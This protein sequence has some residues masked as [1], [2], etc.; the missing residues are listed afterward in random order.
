MEIHF[1]KF[2][3]TRL[4]RLNKIIEKW[5]TINKQKQFSQKKLTN[6]FVKFWKNKWKKHQTKSFRNSTST[7]IK[8]IEKNTIQLHQKF[9][10]AKS[11][12]TTQIR[13]ENIELTNFFIQTQN[14]RH[15]FI[16]MSLWISK[17]N[18]ETCN[19]FVFTT[20]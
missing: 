18:Y 19:C 4:R 20:R 3:K 5:K 15:W 2:K 12:L 13:I 9:A 11:L 16:D 7:K 14:F 8:K 6:Y 1:S 17:T 10:K